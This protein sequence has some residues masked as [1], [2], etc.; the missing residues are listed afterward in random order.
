MRGIAVDQHINTRRRENDLAE[1]I[2]AHPELLGIGIDESTAIVVKGDQFEI[3]GA[4]QVAIT[5]GNRHEGRS[6]YFMIP[7][8]HFDLKNRAK[9]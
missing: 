8:N 5:D 3:I 1:V 4:G 6:F 7:G 2:T 9:R